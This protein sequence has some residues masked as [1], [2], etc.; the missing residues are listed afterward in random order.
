MENNTGIF[1]QIIEE[2][3]ESYNHAKMHIK[4]KKWD[5][6][7][8]G[9]FAPNVLFSSKEDDQT[10]VDETI[11]S[12]AKENDVNLIEITEDNNILENIWKRASVNYATGGSLSSEYFLTNEEKFNMLNTPNTILYFSRIDK[13]ENKLFRRRILSFMNNQSVTFG[14]DKV[15]FAKNILFSVFTISDEMDK[16]ERREFIQDSK[17]GFVIVRLSD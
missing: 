8:Q 1:A 2:L 14:D 12:W 11:K 13:M 7:C 6:N 17:D 10:T 5:P 4:L 16:F 15:H 9:A 3:N